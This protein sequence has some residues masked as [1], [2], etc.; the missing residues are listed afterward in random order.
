MGASENLAFPVLELQ[1]LEKRLREAPNS[2]G[3]SGWRVAG[4]PVMLFFLSS[5]PCTNIASVRHLEGDELHKSLPL[6]HRKIIE[7]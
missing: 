3:D 6:E 1:E 4:V 5:L 2:V 7:L